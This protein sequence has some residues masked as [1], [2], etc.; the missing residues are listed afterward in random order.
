MVLLRFVHVFSG[1][2]PFGQS[3]WHRSEQ[4]GVKRISYEH[5][6][7]TCRHL[8]F[9]YW[10]AESKENADACPIEMAEAAEIAGQADT[11]FDV[12][13]QPVCNKELYTAI[14]VIAGAVIR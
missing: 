8:F 4:S 2:L 11:R 13:L 9:R 6:I 1:L 3:K 7:V 12:Q 5:G 10:N 14:K